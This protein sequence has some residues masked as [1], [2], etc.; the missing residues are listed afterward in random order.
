MQYRGLSWIL[1]LCASALACAHNT[2]LQEQPAP[3]ATEHV[4][5]LISD[6]LL[7]DSTYHSMEGPYHQLRFT[8]GSAERADTLWITGITADVVTPDLAA[9]PVEYF[10]HANLDYDPELHRRLFNTSRMTSNRLFTL[11][12][13]NEAMRFPDGFGI[14]VRSDEPLY[15]TTQVLSNNGVEAAQQV[16]VRIRL[17]YVR[18]GERPMKSLFLT[19]ATGMVS[20]DGH[21]GH[22]GMH[23]DHHVG[24]ATAGVAKSG[25]EYRDTLGQRFSGHWVVPPGK[26]SVRTVVTKWLNLDSDKR[27]HH[28]GVHVHPFAQRITLR[29][30]TAG[31]DVFSSLVTPL[32]GR[33]G[34]SKVT[35][36]SSEAG[37][38]LFADHHYELVADYENPTAQ[39]VDAMAVLFLYMRDPRL[40][41]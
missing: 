4:L 25:H 33:I 39:P 31:R 37:L 11:S 18:K 9:L 23:A 14:P 22:F 5:T 29:D 12:Q 21:E 6:T 41:P 32:D 27:V 34:I 28:I 17:Q 2:P 38:R 7:I 16:R 1:P 10:C 26:H 8:I 35:D 36:L 30:M 13:G 19:S 40:E 15:L 24:S 20:T 3:P